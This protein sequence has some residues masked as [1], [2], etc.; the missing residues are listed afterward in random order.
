MAT[1]ITFSKDVLIGDKP[2]AAGTYSLFTI[3]GQSEWTV[4]VNKRADQSGAF[5]YKEAED[6]LR[7]KVT[8]QANA[9]RER[10]TFIFSNFDERSASLDLEWEKLRVSIPIKV[11]TD[12]Q[13]LAAIKSMGDSSWRPYNLAARWML[14]QK[15]YD[16][17]LKLVDKSIALKEEWSNVYTKASL[18]AGKGRY[19]EAVS[20]GE[21]AQSLGQK[22]PQQFFGADEV[23]RSLTEWKKK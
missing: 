6:V 4:I 2:V 5:T 18:M 9:P 7:L 10:L 13:A 11:K 3:P 17:G 22:Q 1:K 12:E 20:L 8:P 15:S 19:K 23:K 21:R 14:E 16:E